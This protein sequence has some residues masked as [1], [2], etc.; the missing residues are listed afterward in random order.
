VCGPW[1]LVLRGGTA[2]VRVGDSASD[3]REE[4]REDKDILAADLGIHR[5]QPIRLTLWR[6][7]AVS[8]A[9]MLE[10]LGRRR[11]DTRTWALGVEKK[12]GGTRAIRHISNKMSLHVHPAHREASNQ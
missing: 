4:R 1:H 9:S 11:V 12:S 2:N 5:K 10:C 8:K 3:C 7:H 6:I